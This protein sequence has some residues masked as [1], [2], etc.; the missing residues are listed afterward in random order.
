[1]WATP[2]DMQ[3]F[4]LEAAAIAEMD[5]PHIVPLY[6][7][8][9]WTPDGALASLPYY[10]M[11]WVE[12]GSLASRI[13]QFR[14]KPREAVALLLTV[15][16]AVQHAHERGILHRDLKPA[17]ILLTEAGGKREGTREEATSSAPSLAS[18]TP[19][20]TDFGLA[21]RLTAESGNGSRAPS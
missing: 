9:E 17:N 1:T 21:K 3:R 7:V 11:K 4:R 12:G 14:G 13:E 19:Y 18:P 20:V 2:A 5:H 10:S 8:G 15:T 6:E 16:R